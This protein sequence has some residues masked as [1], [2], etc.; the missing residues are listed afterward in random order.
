MPNVSTGASDAQRAANLANAQKS[1]GPASES[2][3]RRARLNAY[4]H[5]LTGQICI[6]T[7]EEQQAFDQHCAGIREALAPVGPLETYLAQSIA[8]D[9]WRL[10][11]AR[12]LEGGIFALGQTP[13]AE[14]HDLGEMQV[15][16][17]LNQAR[18]WLLESRNLQLLALYEQRIQRAAEKN[19]AH[20]GKLQA[21]RKAALSQA[22][23]DAQ[24]L[25]R[26]AI[27][28]GET[29]D[30]AKDAPPELRIGF[31][32][33]AAGIRDIVTR[34]ERLREARYHADRNWDAEFP[35]REPAIS[36]SAAA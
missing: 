25:T 18:T 1:T 3:K 9:Q 5:G 30:A 28:K 7:T 11:R 20:L 24:L 12:S 17:A 31:D 29:Y 14:V 19:M 35:Y 26:L 23:E 6:F 16:E 15:D 2:G 33:S 8:Q 34:G 32:F 10:T 21:E 22:I 13:A 4:R 27:M 36:L